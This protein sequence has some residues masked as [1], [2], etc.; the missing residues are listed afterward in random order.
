MRILTMVL[1]LFLTDTSYS[2]QTGLENLPLGISRSKVMQA[3]KKAKSLDKSLT[4]TVKGNDI[5]VG[6]SQ[7]GGVY[8]FKNGFLCR[9]LAIIPDPNRSALNIILNSYNFVARSANGQEYYVY[10][11]SYEN[12]IKYT[13]TIYYMYSDAYNGMCTIGTTT[14]TD[15]EQ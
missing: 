3:V 12:G 9:I 13:Q 2:Q 1:L 11:G 4:V 6:N 7:Y 10:N 5:L 8:S 14:Y 15:P